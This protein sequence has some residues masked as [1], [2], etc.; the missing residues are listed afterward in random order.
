MNH[1]A[2][3]V[4]LILLTIAASSQEP[5]DSIL[6]R[7]QA[8]CSVVANNACVAIPALVE[9]GQLDRAMEVCNAWGARCGSNALFHFTHAVLIMKLG[10]PLAADNPA[11]YMDRLL[12]APMHPVRN[13]PA[14]GVY[15]G[16]T[17]DGYR[18]E[19]QRRLLEFLYGQCLGLMGNFNT[20]T[21]EH[22]TCMILT[23]QR[24]KALKELRRPPFLD[25][26]YYAHYQGRRREL[27]EASGMHAALR[28]G[29]W[30]GAG[31]TAKLGPQPVLGLSIGGNFRNGD[32]MDL[33]VEGLAG[34]SPVDPVQIT[35]L[36]SVVTTDYV[37]GLY[38]ALEYDKVIWRSLDYR[39]RIGI[40]GGVGY[41]HINLVPERY[42]GSDNNN[43]TNNNSNNQDLEYR[44]Y[45]GSITASA[46]LGYSYFLTPA[47]YLNA[48]S[49]Y[50]LHDYRNSGGTD[51]RGTNITTTIGFGF[52]M[53]TNTSE[54]RRKL[55]LGL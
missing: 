6:F 16:W 1:I 44:K 41:S 26:P 35:L 47:V 39:H 14:S 9:Q 23:G 30:Q 48:T 43:N 34:G 15:S 22:L 37:S 45:I 2:L 21:L 31:E 13:R 17:N 54:E 19:E 29:L 33:S 40:R 49:K 36:D 3:I 42:R 7:R 24:E 38:V 10:Q 27:Y 28:A 11:V 12:D 18:P 50:F 55:G 53:G 25:S 20:G 46:A 5:A 32:F 51:I 8:D 4:S 52:I